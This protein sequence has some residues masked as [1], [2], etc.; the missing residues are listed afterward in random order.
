MP[1]VRPDRLYPLLALHCIHSSRCIAVK[2]AGHHFKRGRCQDLLNP[3]R[4][5]FIKIRVSQFPRAMDQMITRLQ[6]ELPARLEL[7]ELAL[8]QQISHDS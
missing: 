2:F 8:F 3:S 5:S 4:L 7:F 1:P 6:I